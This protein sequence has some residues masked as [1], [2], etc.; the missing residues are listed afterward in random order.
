MTLDERQTALRLAPAIAAAFGLVLALAGAFAPPE[1]APGDAIAAHLVLPLPGWLVLAAVIALGLASLIF[2]AIIVQRPR[3]RKKKGDDDFELY[4]EPR[5]IPPILAVALLLLAL[6]PGAVLGGAIFWFGQ[7]NLTV[8]PG[9]GAAH[10]QAAPP[11]TQPPPAKAPAEAEKTASPITIGLIGA[12]A[13]LV[14][15]G[16][17]GFVLWLFLGDRWLR[18]LSPGDDIPRAAFA[19]AVDDSL[20]ELRRE[21]DPRVAIIKIYR[22]FERA[23]AVA[24]MPRPAWQTPVEFMRAALAK[25]PLPGDAVRELTGLFEL[26]RFSDHPVGAGDREDAWRSLLDIRAALDRDKE[27]RDGAVS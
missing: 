14:G 4:Y 6:A 18:H 26:A 22:N 11:A 16:S 25:L 2:L 3:R 27:A 1:G 23:L 19:A 15:L 13:L 21:T 20:D 7:T 10:T 12:M 8:T 17:L 9:G 5:K 24:S